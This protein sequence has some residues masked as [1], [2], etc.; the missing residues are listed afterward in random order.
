MFE[1]NK[2]TVQYLKLIFFYKYIYI[3]INWLVHLQILRMDRIRVLDNFKTQYQN[4]LKARVVKLYGKD[5]LYKTTLKL[6][7]TQRN[8]N[9]NQVYKR[10]WTSTLDEKGKQLL[11][12][13]QLIKSGGYWALI[14]WR[15]GEKKWFELAGFTKD[16]SI[17]DEN[18]RNIKTFVKTLQDLGSF[19]WCLPNL[20]FG[21]GKLIETY[22]KYF[23][24]KYAL[25]FYK[26]DDYDRA[27]E[28]LNNF[29]MNT[30]PNQGIK[31][32]GKKFYKNILAELTVLQ[33]EGGELKTA[34][35]DLIVDSKYSNVENTFWE[36]LKFFSRNK[37]I[38]Q[39]LLDMEDVDI[40]KRSDPLEPYFYFYWEKKDNQNVFQHDAQSGSDGDLSND[41][42]VDVTSDEEDNSQ[43]DGDRTESSDS[44]YVPPADETEDETEDEEEE[45][46][47]AD[48]KQE[49]P[50]ADEKQVTKDDLKTLAETLEGN[51]KFGNYTEQVVEIIK[52]AWRLGPEGRKSAYNTIQRWDAA[53]DDVDVELEG[54][55]NALKTVVST[56]YR[57]KLKRRRP[58][59]R[60]GG[61]DNY[62]ESFAYT[63]SASLKKRYDR[64][65]SLVKHNK[66]MVYA[67]MHNDQF[68]KQ[69]SLMC[70]DYSVLN[71]LFLQN[72]PINREKFLRMR[73]RT[74]EYLTYQD[75][76]R[77]LKACT[78]KPLKAFVF[79]RAPGFIRHMQQ[80]LK[81][82]YCLWIHVQDHHLA[83]ISTSSKG[84]VC[85]NTYGKSHGYGGFSILPWKEILDDCKSYVY[86]E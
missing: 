28:A 53:A 86:F 42:L 76:F 33:S 15:G 51:R 13:E 40:G 17:I 69:E 59:R 3:Y 70:A 65:L 35:K 78:T 27:R 44:D 36:Q 54:K 24:P 74:R 85:L 60:I 49:D 71:V 25:H 31:V 63:P 41:N 62:L 79:E 84:L 19:Y 18:N 64:V 45:V 43:F 39:E 48:E 57:E 1:T 61:A 26:D 11:D 6:K 75:F 72:I 81:N 34:L 46:P 67:A 21:Y 22:V 77:L 30:N 23:E 82:G 9:A 7:P 10:L 66:H 68:Y 8:R 29:F 58:A 5:G 2:Y 14:A 12:N 37:P 73:R 56:Q 20:G 50:Q 16:P 38:P 4:E 80:C 32:E 47:Q 83:A 55:I 52:I